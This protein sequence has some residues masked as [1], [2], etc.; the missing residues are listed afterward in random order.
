MARKSRLIQV[1][2]K[3]G[4]QD[5]ILL[6]SDRQE[7]GLDNEYCGLRRILSLR[8]TRSTD[9]IRTCIS[10]TVSSI[11][12]WPIYCSYMCLES[13]VEMLCIYIYACYYQKVIFIHVV[14]IIDI[15]QVP[16]V[17]NS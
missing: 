6:Y 16:L 5:H 11:E 14:K 13:S 12:P 8:I 15:N 3:G 1:G 2:K 10:C 9:Y 17:G 7:L 4:R